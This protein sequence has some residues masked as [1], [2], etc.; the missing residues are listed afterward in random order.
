M[1]IVAAVVDWL[2]RLEIAQKQG[3]KM[4]SRKGNGKRVLPTGRLSARIMDYLRIKRRENAVYKR[5]KID[6]VI[7]IF[8]DDG[9]T[10][11]YVKIKAGRKRMPR[12]IQLI[13][14]AF[15]KMAEFLKCTYVFNFRL[16]SNTH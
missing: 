14:L 6:T 5:P 13:Q 7:D 15:R 10:Y 11:R 12:R 16:H 2:L 9:S 8:F 3:K 1:M 4:P